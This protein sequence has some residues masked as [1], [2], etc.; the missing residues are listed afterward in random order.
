MRGLG[1]H[2]VTAFSLEEWGSGTERHTA[3]AKESVCLCVCTSSYKAS[4]I[5]SLDS[6]LMTLSNPNHFPEAPLLSTKVSLSFHSLNTSQLG[7]NFHPWSFGIL[8]NHIHSIEI[9]NHFFSCKID[10]FLWFSLTVITIIE[11]GHIE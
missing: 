9:P 5:Q 4:R 10:N 11:H 1:S 2:L 7:L 8:S 3:R 6:M